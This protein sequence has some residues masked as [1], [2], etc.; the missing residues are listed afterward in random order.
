VV[1]P[2]PKRRS[3]SPQPDTTIWRRASDASAAVSAVQAWPHLAA[4]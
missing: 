4:S 2:E 1:E 3:P